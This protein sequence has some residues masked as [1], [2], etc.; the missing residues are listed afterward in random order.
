VHIRVEKARAG[1][2]RPPSDDYEVELNDWRCSWDPTSDY[3]EIENSHSAFIYVR[4]M[5][6]K[7][8]PAAALAVVRLAIGS[9]HRDRSVGWPQPGAV[10]LGRRAAGSGHVLGRARLAGAPGDLRRG[11]KLAGSSQGRRAA[12]GG[13]G[14][15]HVV[16]GA[17]G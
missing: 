10:G 17:P 6:G 13:T 11:W 15:G 9:R 2:W 4:E 12:S 1:A 3:V 5:I 7:S 16:D 8:V 14:L